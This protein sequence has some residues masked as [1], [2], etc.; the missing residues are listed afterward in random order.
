MEALP[1]ACL[2]APNGGVRQPERFVSRGLGRRGAQLPD[3]AA[4]NVDQSIPAPKNSALTHKVF[5]QW[6]RLVARGPMIPQI[7][8]EVKPAT[9]TDFAIS[10]ES[11]RTG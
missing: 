10:R 4:V 7:G 5:S 9:A 6:Y 8:A 2:G 3:R 1:R 11:A